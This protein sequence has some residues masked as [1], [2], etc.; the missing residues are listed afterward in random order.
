MQGSSHVPTAATQELLAQPVLLPSPFLEDAVKGF[1]EKVM[2]YKKV[3][4]DLEQV[5]GE[6]GGSRRN[7]F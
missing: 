7:G 5:K 4:A 6:G 3:M 2:E 1:K